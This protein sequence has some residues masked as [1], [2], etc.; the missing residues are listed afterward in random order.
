LLHYNQLAERHRGLY[1]IGPVRV[2]AA[3][4]LGVFYQYRELPCLTRLT[5]YPKANP[6]PDYSIPGV[7]AG[8]GPSLNVVDRVGQ[9]EQVLGVR[10]Y[11]AGDPPGRVHWR[12]SARHRRLHVIEVD[13]P[14]QAE[15][16]IMIDLSRRSRFGLG[17][18]ATSE[19]AIHAATSILTRAQETR[20]RFSLAYAHKE[21]VMFPPGAGLAHLHLLLDRLAVISPAGE[22]NLWADLAPR[23]LMLAPGSRAVLIGPAATVPLETALALIRRLVQRGVA[24]DFVLI[25]ERDFIKI[26]KDQEVDVRKGLP[27]FDTLRREFT[28]AG[29]RVWALNRER[30]TL[31]G[32]PR[33]EV[34][35]LERALAQQ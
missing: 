35:I 34:E 27:D 30:A 17:A 14:I 18:E 26:Y 12:T 29:A 8:P 5:V 20:H 9:G 3:D 31:A 2:R 16:A 32:I 11:A 33:A 21:P 22:T 15:L 10:E 1:M 19:L 6:L 28:L 25:D 23:A 4:P 7:L 24:T 13:R